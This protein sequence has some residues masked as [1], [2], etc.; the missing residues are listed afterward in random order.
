VSPELTQA[1]YRIGDSVANVVTPLNP[2]L[3]IVL[4]LLQR[5][6]RGA[7]IGTLVALMLPYAVAFGV[8]W[9]FLLA[10]WVALGIP[11]GPAGPLAYT[12]LP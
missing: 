10:L 9:T 4:V 7:G 8:A 6:A 5:Y 1:A 12:P 3:V 11:L 2:Y